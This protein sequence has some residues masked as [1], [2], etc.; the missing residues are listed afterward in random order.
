MMEL[1]F[2]CMKLTKK[3]VLRL[4]KVLVESLLSEDAAKLVV[5]FKVG[6]MEKL[7]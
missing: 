3:L 2:I 7:Y 4:E 1:N 5:K 6:M